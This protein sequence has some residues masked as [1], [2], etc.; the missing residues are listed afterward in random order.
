MSIITCPKALSYE[1]IMENCPFW[2]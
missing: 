1:L 2:L